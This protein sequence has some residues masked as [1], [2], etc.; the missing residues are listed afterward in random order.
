MS[1]PL[2]VGTKLGTYQIVALLGT[3]GMGEVYRASDLRL[4]RD[5]ALKFLRE[6]FAD[7]RERLQRFKREAQVLASLSN[8]HIAAIYGFEEL[9]SVCFLAMELV[10]GPTLAERIVAGPI[11]VEDALQIAK[12]IASALESAHEKNIIHRDLKPLNIKLTDEGLVKLLDFGLAKALERETGSSDI[13]TSPTISDIASQAGVL[14]GTAAYMSPEQA[15]GKRTDTRTDIWAFGVV[16]YEMLTRRQAFGGEDITEI[17]AAI[18]RG[19]PDWTVLPDDVP[20]TIRR[21]LT[22]CLKKD[23]KRR[24]RDIGDARMEIEEV[25]DQPADESAMTVIAA[26][27]IRPAWRAWVPWGLTGLLAILVCV[28]FWGPWRNPPP[29]PTPMWLSVEIGADAS[30][31]DAG[32]A[33]SP[34]G[35]MFV[36]TAIP[37]GGSVSKIFVRHLN[38]AQAAAL[39]DSDDARYPFFSP[40]SR[41]IG[42]FSHGK[43]K[44][45]SVNG[46]A[47]ISLCDQTSGR[48]AA[49]GENG[50][51]VFAP[52]PVSPLVRV[53]SVGGSCEPVTKLDQGQ[54]EITHRWPLILPGARTVVFEAHT[55]TDSFQDAVIVAQSLK[56][57]TRKTVVQGAMFP[58]YLPA[59]A[60]E[61]ESNSGVTGY[62]LYVH[63]GSLFAAA[64]DEDRLELASPA[65]PVLES[66]QENTHEGSAAL[67]VSTTGSL[68]YFP[69]ASLRP[70]SSILWIN[71]DGK[72]E[73]LRPVPAGYSNIKFSPDGRRL[74]L[75]IGP[76]LVSA[77][78]LY[79]WKQDRMTRLTLGA[80]DNIRPIWTPD[81]QRITFASDR[82][83]PGITNLYWQRADGTGET[84]RL[85]ESEHLQRPGS[86]HPSGR[87]LAYQ[88]LRPPNGFDIMMLPIEGS[89]ITGWTPGK[90]YAFLDS[91]A[92]EVVPTFSPDGRWLAYMSNESGQLEVYVRPFPGPG[93]KSQISTDLGFN[94]IWARDGKSLF[95]QARDGRIMVVKYDVS[96]GV[97][98]AEKPGLW[99]SVPVPLRGEG[100]TTADLSPD[101][102]RFAVLRPLDMQDGTKLDRVSFIFNFTEVLRN[103]IQPTKR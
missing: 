77:I 50:E 96:R 43:L 56:T 7:D 4:G 5:V 49:W 74:A 32:G 100:T 52:S 67:A 97:F 30:L 24:L 79:D 16:L 14:L 51:I 3:G 29:P 42:F 85:A 47:P 80:G 33:L 69:L 82:A 60:D 101:G 81:G 75:A 99:C 86:W 98:D 20:W 70:Q 10:E 8:P 71:R 93:G 1:M 102:V 25:L 12:Q 78:W 73:A 103:V 87:V 40:D 68:V 95:Y 54:K 76:A 41:W 15:K 18:I 2:A 22:R 27:P 58:Q 59:S 6:A 48:G 84:Q 11:P 90:P 23:A 39:P 88:E 46:G 38:Q 89:D 63:E 53:S 36:F 9:G 21:L 61:V 57:E 37:S 13:S 26:N 94:P 62:L 31:L 19:E 92:N 65:T 35:T 55:S 91:P 64:F 28:A 72:T 44:K 66:L 17:L 45:I 34:D 83:K